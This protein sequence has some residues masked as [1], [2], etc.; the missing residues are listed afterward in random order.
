M[1]ISVMGAA[2]ALMFAYQANAAGPV[3]FGPIKV[4]MSKEELQMLT[5]VD[6]V[7]LNAPLEPNPSKYSESIPG[8][9]RLKAFITT[10]ISPKPLAATFIFSA[11]SLKFFKIYLDNE[12][13]LDHVKEKITEKYGAPQIIDKR[14]EE[15]CIYKNDSNFKIQSGSLDYRWSEKSNDTIVTTVETYVLD[16]CPTSLRT[17]IPASKSYALS[18]G[19]SNPKKAKT[20]N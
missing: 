1:R 14:K 7:Y 17:A 6:S 4:G 19:V 12:Y 5:T 10:D 11:N 2:I 16:M 18:I 9:E 8:V 13:L 20:D 15:Q 3:G